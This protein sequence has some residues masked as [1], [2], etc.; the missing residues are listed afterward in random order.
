MSWYGLHISSIDRVHPLAKIL[1]PSK[2]RSGCSQSAIGWN[3]GP[4]VED[5]E[6]VPKVLK[7]SATL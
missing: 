7:E 5:L 6:K 4:S 1:F 2:H 3:T